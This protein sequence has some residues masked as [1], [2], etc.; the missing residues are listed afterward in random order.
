MSIRIFLRTELTVEKKFKPLFRQITFKKS[1]FVLV[2]LFLFRIK[3]KRKFKRNHKES[4][5]KFSFLKR[6]RIDDNIEVSIQQ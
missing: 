5:N 6:L 1:F 2:K 4:C 3:K